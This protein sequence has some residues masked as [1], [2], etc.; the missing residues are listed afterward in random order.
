MDAAMLLLLSRYEH[1][2]RDGVVSVQSQTPRGLCRALPPTLRPLYV[3]AAAA[4]WMLP[5][6]LRW[7]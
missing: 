3:D 1:R 5:I 6:G 7:L 4:Y 2:S